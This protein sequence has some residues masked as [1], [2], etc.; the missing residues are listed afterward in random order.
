[1]IH[2]E[3]KLK[4]ESRDTVPLSM[5]LSSGDKEPFDPPLF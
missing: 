3:R 2:E 4:Q 5:N 1:M